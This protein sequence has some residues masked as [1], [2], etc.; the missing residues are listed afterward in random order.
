MRASSVFTGKQSLVVNRS[1]KNWAA[2]FTLPMPS[3]FTQPL[4]VIFEAGW[5]FTIWWAQALRLSERVLRSTQ[6][7]ALPA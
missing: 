7:L 2:K 4:S 6:R 1:S 3:V 5:M